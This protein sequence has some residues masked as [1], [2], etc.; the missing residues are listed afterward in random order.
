M[1]QLF[2]T[3][4]FTGKIPP[5]WVHSIVV[6]IAK[7]NQP[8]HL[9]F[10][11]RPTSLT[12]NVC[13]FFEKMVVCRLS[14]FLE[15]YKILSISESGFRQRRKTTDHILRLND[16]IQKSLGNKHNVLS[17]FIDLEKA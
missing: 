3:I 14:W 10:S 7:P 5:S 15:Y 8:S 17:V 13:K 12:S 6:P 2:N 11:Y 9:P 1:L 16:A 4:W